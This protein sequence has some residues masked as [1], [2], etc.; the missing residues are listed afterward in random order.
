M[1][2]KDE[3]CKSWE[4]ALDLGQIVKQYISKYCK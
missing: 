4:K 1:K 2:K 3:A